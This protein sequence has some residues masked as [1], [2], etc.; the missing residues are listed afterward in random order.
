MKTSLATT[1]SIVGV[2]ATGGV[3]FAVNTS[4]LDS[5][6]AAVTATPALPEAIVPRAES[7]FDFEGSPTD[8]TVPVAVASTSVQSAYDVDGAGIVTLAQDGTSLTVVSVLPVSGWTFDTSNEDAAGVEVEF[9]NGAQH[10]KFRAELLDGR[11]VTSVQTEVDEAK[12]AD[13]TNGVDEE[14]GTDDGHGSDD[15]VNESKE[16]DGNE[17]EDD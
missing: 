16:D 10:M 7:P 13:D 8:S 2:L 11:I 9:T 1:L 17:I 4:V 14:N 6:V 12:G 15:G 3:A 5:S